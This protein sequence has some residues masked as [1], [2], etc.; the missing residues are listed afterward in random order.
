M[1][2]PPYI[3]RSDIHKRLQVIFPDGVENRGYCVREMAASTVFVLLYIGAVHGTG[4]WLAPKHVM[5][6]TAEQAELSSDADRIAYAKA[7][8]GKKFKVAGVR[9]YEENSREGV[10]DETIKQGLI[11]NGA[12]VERLG[13]ATT[14]AYPRYALHPDFAALFEPSLEEDAFKTA[15]VAWQKKHLSPEALARVALIGSGSA[16]ATGEITVRFPSGDTRRMAAGPSSVISKAVIE[17]FAPRFLRDPVVLFLSESREKVIERDEK[18]AAKLKLKISAD[19]TLPDLIL[20]D[21]SSDFLIVFVE[22]VSSDGPVSEARKTA[23]LKLVTDAG[24][25]AEQAA[26]VTAFR[27]RSHGA[28][29]KTVNSLAWNSFAWFMAE[30]SQI[31]ILRDGLSAPGKLVQLIASK[32]I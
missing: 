7:A 30:P 1:T 5:R 17:D 9:W 25:S 19:K 29:K 27:D 8:M 24:F 11:V 20:V 4:E 13:L 2:L 31:M 22:V 10:R 6:M 21:M 14:S 28:F 26:F 16:S 32:T 15:A 23:L 12:A 18:L 3:S